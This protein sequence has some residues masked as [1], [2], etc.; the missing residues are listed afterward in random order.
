LFATKANLFSPARSGEKR[1]LLTL[2]GY[3]AWQIF[4]YNASPLQTQECGFQ[5]HP[6]DKSHFFAPFAFFAANSPIPKWAGRDR[7]LLCDLCALCG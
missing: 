1:V 4:P 5:I 2:K 3:A 7:P 6:L